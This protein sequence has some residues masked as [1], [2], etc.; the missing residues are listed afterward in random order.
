PY[1]TLIVNLVGCFVIA[2]VMQAALQ[3]AW[4]PTLR[5]AVAVGFVGGLT[6]YS[7]FNYET[8]TLIAN[9]ASTAAVSNVMLT[10]VGGDASG[11][12]G[13]RAARWACRACGWWGV[14]T[15]KWAF[16]G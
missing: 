11:R 15:G 3:F 5:M 8:M 16:G 2:A 6:T 1:G 7:S 14:A 10:L 4:S 12:A 9:G 13:R